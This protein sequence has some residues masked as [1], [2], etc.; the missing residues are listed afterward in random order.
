MGRDKRASRAARDPG[1]FI[2][3]PW[4]VMDCPAYA[5]LSHPARSLLLELAR[6]Y[7]RDNN[8]RLVASRA[9]LALRGWTSAD[10]IQRAKGELLAAGFIHETVKGRRPNRASWYALT[11]FGLDR[12]A[13]YDPGAAETFLRGAYRKNAIPC[14]SHGTERRPIAPSGGTERAAPV[15][16]HGAMR[17]T[18]A[19]SPVP[20][21]GHHLETPSVPMKTDE[22]P[23]AADRQPSLRDGPTI[24]LS[25]PRRACPANVPGT[26]QGQRIPSPRLT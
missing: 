21:G 12:H 16:S 23:A 6:Q 20:S 26:S 1:G 22:G 5:A 2:A 8:G 10:V 17:A 13:D 18:F 7:V 9:Y 25:A 11:W 19:T 4:S 15:P 3:L 14:P 24:S